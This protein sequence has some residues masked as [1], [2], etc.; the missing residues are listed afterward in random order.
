MSKITIKINIV[1]WTGSLR[2]DGPPGIA[3]YARW[4]PDVTEVEKWKQSFCNVMSSDAGRSVFSEFLKSEFS[5]EN[6]DFWMSC[7]DYKRAA[8]PTLSSRA[9]QIYQQYVKADAPKE[10]NLD[11]ET[12]EETRL[13]VENPSPLCFDKAQ[14]MIFTLMEKDSYRR[15][16]KSKL[17]QDLCVKEA[18]GG[19]ETEEQK[20]KS[21]E[22]VAS[23]KV[24]ASG[25]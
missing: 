24:L 18:N 12:R 3:Q 5:E 16:L 8:P 23:H 22:C 20:K 11:A 13:N 7:E 6:L 15:F 4:V 9:K 21:C 19:Q 17:L 10:V 2:V 1:H 14:K 25:A